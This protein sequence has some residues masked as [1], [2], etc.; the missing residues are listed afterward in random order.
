MRYLR[1]RNGLGGIISCRD[2]ST[3]YMNNERMQATANCLEEHTGS[4]YDSIVRNAVGSHH[5]LFVSLLRTC[6]TLP[7]TS[8]SPGRRAAYISVR[9]KVLHLS[10]AM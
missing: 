6:V 5:W 3:V 2:D 9:T 1:C 10:K 8:K 4:Y 7:Y